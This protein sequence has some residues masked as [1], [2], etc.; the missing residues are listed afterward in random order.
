MMKWNELGSEDCSLARALS[1]VGDRWT[2]LIL[3]DAFL[4]VRRFE[5]FERSLKISRRS[6]SERL[7]G[8]VAAGIL[9]RRPYQ[10]RPVRHEYRLTEKGVGLLPALLALIHWGDQWY[11]GEQGPPVRHRHRRC[12]HVF[13][14]SLCC[15]E[16]GEPVSA[17]DVVA[18]RRP[19]S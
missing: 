9:E 11:A 2:L 3:R 8:L 13:R 4:K 15:S 17:L 14:S 18:E 19:A 6:L 12:G 1:A 7:D 5:D 16:C 10:E